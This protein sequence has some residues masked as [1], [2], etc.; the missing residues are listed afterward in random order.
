M[1][2]DSIIQKIES[3]A[4]DVAAREAVVIYDIEFGGGPQGPVLRIFIDK[5]GGVGIEDCANVS[6]GLSVLL[7]ETDPLP[8]GNYQLE[9]SSPG[10]ERPLKKAWH[11]EQA[12]GKKV[13][14]KF[15]RALE[16]FGCTEA[17]FKTAKQ[18][19][20]VLVSVRAGQAELEL[21]AELVL[22]PLDQIEKAKLVFEYNDGKQSKK[23]ASPKGARN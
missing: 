2:S 7:D 6:R 20:A 23:G 8:G 3:L 22:V 15:S 18:V 19:S 17:Q 5:E 13:W 10:L 4:A 14:F 12:V 11:F 16:S 1:I 21:G 9:V